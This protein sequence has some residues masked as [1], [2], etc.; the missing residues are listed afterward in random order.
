MI[1][2]SILQEDITF[3]N[4]YIL[5]NSVPKYMRQKLI[6]LQGEIDTSIIIV[7]NF[8]TPLSEMDRSSRQKNQ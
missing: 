6:E 3:F 7:G 4:V 5:N 2:E 1:K 8:N